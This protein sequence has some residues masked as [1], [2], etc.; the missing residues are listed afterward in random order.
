[1]LE[2]ATEALEKQSDD[3]PLKFVIPWSFVHPDAVLS[4]ASAITTRAGHATP[5]ML[6]AFRGNASVVESLLNHG[7]NENIEGNLNGAPFECRG[8]L[9]LEFVYHRSHRPD[10]NFGFDRDM[11][12]KEH[13]STEHRSR[14]IKQLTHTEQQQSVVYG[15]FQKAIEERDLWTVESALLAHMTPESIESVFRRKSSNGR[16]LLLQSATIDHPKITRALLKAG[17]EIADLD[18]H[19]NSVFDLAAS[20]GN[21]RT[22][23]ELLRESR[24]P[25]AE[26]LNHRNTH[27]NSVVDNLILH[28][29]SKAN[30]VSAA[31]ADSVLV[32]LLQN[33]ATMPMD[34]LTGQNALVWC[35][36][37]DWWTAAGY[38]L[39]TCR[40]PGD[41]SRS[42]SFG[43]TVAHY[44]AQSGHHEF[45]KAL[46]QKHAQLNSADSSGKLPLHYASAGIPSGSVPVSRDY[47]K[48]VQILT[49]SGANQDVHVTD[50]NGQSSKDIA[51]ENN[52]ESILKYFEDHC[53][54]IASQRPLRRD[55]EA[56][57]GDVLQLISNSPVMDQHLQNLGVQAK[58]A[59]EYANQC[60]VT[61][62]MVASAIA[63]CDIVEQLIDIHE[64]NINQ[65]VKSEEELLDFQSAINFW[66]EVGLNPGSTA[67]HAAVVGGRAD[68]VAVLRKHGAQIV[69]DHGRVP[70]DPLDMAL[71]KSKASLVLELIQF[72][73]LGMEQI[74]EKARKSASGIGHKRVM[75]MLHMLSHKLLLLRRCSWG[76]P[77]S[78]DFAK[79]IFKPGI[80]KSDLFHSMAEKCIHLS[81]QYSFR[82]MVF[83]SGRIITW[84]RARHKFQI[85]TDEPDQGII[86]GRDL[87]TLQSRDVPHQTA[88]VDLRRFSG[89]TI[90][91]WKR[92]DLSDVDF[93]KTSHQLQ[94]S[95]SFANWNFNL[96]VVVNRRQAYAL[97]V[98]L[99]TLHPASPTL[100]AR[101]W[102]PR[103]FENQRVEDAVLAEHLGGAVVQE[104]KSLALIT[105]VRSLD[106][107][108]KQVEEFL[109]GKDTSFTIQG[110]ANSINLKIPQV[111]PH[112]DPL[113]PF[114]GQVI[115]GFSFDW[116]LTFEPLTD[117]RLG[118]EKLKKEI[119]D[120]KSAGFDQCIIRFKL[121]DIEREHRYEVDFVRSS[122]HEVEPVNMR[123]HEDITF[124]K[125]ALPDAL[126]TIHNGT[127]I[128]GYS[129]QVIA[130]ILFGPGLP[131]NSVDGPADHYRTTLHEA[132]IWGDTAMVKFLAKISPDINI[133]DGLGRTALDYQKRPSTILFSDIKEY[134]QCERDI[135]RFF[136]MCLEFS[137]DGGH[138]RFKNQNISVGAACSVGKKVKVQDHEG[139]FVRSAEIKAILVSKLSRR[140]RSENDVASRPSET[141]SMRTGSE[142]TRQGRRFIDSGALSDQDASVNGLDIKYLVQIGRTTQELRRHEFFM[143]GSMR[144]SRYQHYLVLHPTKDR[145]FTKQHQDEFLT[146]HK[147]HPSIRV[148]S[149]S[150]FHMHTHHACRTSDMILIP[151][152]DG[153]VTRWKHRFPANRAA[154]QRVGQ[155]SLALEDQAPKQIES[156]AASKVVTFADP[157]E[158][159]AMVVPSLQQSSTSA[160][161]IG[162]PHL[163]CKSEAMRDIDARVVLSLEETSKHAESLA[164]STKEHKSAESSKCDSVSTPSTQQLVEK[165]WIQ[166][167]FKDGGQVVNSKTAM[168]IYQD[169]FSRI[170][171]CADI[172]ELVLGQLLLQLQLAQH[173]AIVVTSMQALA[174][175]GNSE[176][177]HFEA[178]SSTCAVEVPSVVS[179][180]RM[181][182]LVSTGLVQLQGKINETIRDESREEERRLRYG[183]ILNDAWW[184]SN[185]FVEQKITGAAVGEN[186]TFHQ[187]VFTDIQKVTGKVERAFVFDSIFQYLHCNYNF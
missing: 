111:L 60:G 42:D 93:R 55:H 144:T 81:V 139:N 140:T 17:A 30:S 143:P 95:Y 157:I 146:L 154:L 129:P 63:S 36:V 56:L 44:A 114:A 78:V 25:L 169:P 97:L 85:Q 172:L 152:H 125:T 18:S 103:G 185:D 29:E 53:S 13:P 98:Y 173:A 67:L 106:E 123:L 52:Q 174:V 41:F 128:S 182:S 43:R 124:E 167:A 156:A 2:I 179:Q 73:G 145:L 134:I 149:E 118:F 162:A 65:R 117:D 186:V 28:V 16:T 66:K 72:P 165:E 132:S 159:G 31:D 168:E 158:S 74:L 32:N 75:S 100:K 116:G 8:S 68:V 161:R 59:A 126:E 57:C 177:N 115:D 119:R 33:G 99:R 22:I 82:G 183:W 94:T 171:G 50:K 135:E 46:S 20:H 151:H 6:A 40:H 155:R 83:Q 5:L 61:I 88:V 7:V 101:D 96:N 58:E 92:A 76:S 89:C 12:T 1:M 47:L 54:E 178:H 79:I 34:T 121:T 131:I 80:A 109:Q 45:L 14:I 181:P 38:L 23:R 164:A 90:S 107:F 102:F 166:T 77:N 110:S 87:K 91:R 147:D 113:H 136:D 21:F 122:I 170:D 176:N 69:Q 137:D 27:G 26:I 24:Q 105:G 49:Q 138:L 19:E 10:C 175:M 112:D 35:L 184:D 141:E 163:E 39:E 62:L 108:K 150:A 142:P 37:H 187:S 148:I 104:L 133:L 86:S 153:S 180:Q 71:K 160:S 4:A 127:D 3:S 70:C 11:M 9:A 120:K 84:V 15:I 64:H 48:C 51:H 130:M